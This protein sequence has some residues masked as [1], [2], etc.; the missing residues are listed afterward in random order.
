MEFQTFLEK[1]KKK[2][3]EKKK[4]KKHYRWEER[5]RKLASDNRRYQE[6]RLKNKVE[7]T[8]TRLGFERRGLKRRNKTGS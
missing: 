4:E 8:K 5:E 7:F 6:L 1:K 2:K 3:K